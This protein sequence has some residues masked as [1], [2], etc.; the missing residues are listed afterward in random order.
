MENK[1]PLLTIIIPCYNEE[2]VLPKT[3]PLFFAT[4]KDMIDKEKIDGESHILFVDDGSSDSTWEIIKDLAKNSAY[5]GIRQSR[6]R[7]HQNAVY[8]GLMESR[9]V[10]DI[11]ISIDCDGQDDQTVMEDMVDAYL[12]GNEIVYGVRK[13][14]NTDKKAKRSTA[15]MY[16]KFLAKLGV[17]IVYNHADYRL[18]SARALEEFAK[19]DETELFLRGMV[20]LV[21]FKN[22]TVYYDRTRR[23]AGESKYPLRKMIGLAKNGI[24]G[25]SMKPVEMI[26]KTGIGLFVIGLVAFLISLLVMLVRGVAG[27]AILGAGLCAVIAAVV[28]VGGIA[29]FSIGIA[30]EYAARANLEAKHRPK[31]IISDRT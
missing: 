29:V 17:D 20:P 2:A 10:A 4:L 23:L 9:G 13:S 15:E 11:T 25:F 28:F 27:K 12:E 1:K 24:F 21:G 14:R 3:A 22:T 8:A 16:Y 5:R 30:G 6:N 7:G 26:E 31:Y 18:I 19:F